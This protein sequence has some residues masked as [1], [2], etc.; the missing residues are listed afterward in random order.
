MQ[1]AAPAAVDRIGFDCLDL[2]LDLVVPH[3]AT[4]E[5]IDAIRCSSSSSVNLGIRPSTVISPFRCRKVVMRAL[6]SLGAVA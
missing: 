6:I 4:P 2:D 3:D 1:V 5:A